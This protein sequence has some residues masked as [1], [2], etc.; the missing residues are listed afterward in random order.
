MPAA[1][2]GR[3]SSSLAS[4]ELHAPTLLWS[5]AAAA[6]R[7][8]EYRGD[9]TADIAEAALRWLETVAIKPTPSSSLIRASR[10]VAMQLGWAK[11]HDAEYVV[12]AQRLGAPLV[13]I[14]ARL[15]ASVADRVT[16]LA[17]TDL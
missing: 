2:A 14:D 11:T 15:R 8:L 9:V 4:E 7:Q 5:E 12:L 13:T 6:L 17:P 10:Q 16:V 1:L 3:W